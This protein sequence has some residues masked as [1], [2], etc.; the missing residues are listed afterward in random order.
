M[1]YLYFLLII[2]LFTVIGSAQK[3]RKSKE[4]SPELFSLIEAERAFAKM[5]LDKGM[6]NAFVANFADDSVF[7]LKTPVNGK[8][9][10]LDYPESQEFLTWEPVFA[11]ISQAG[12]L[13]YTT[14]F[15]EY[16]E[17]PTD[18]KA[19]YANFISV[20]KKQPDG[21]WK[22]ALDLGVSNPKPAAN[23]ALQL[24]NCTQ[25]GKLK[26][27]VSVEAERNALLKLDRELSEKAVKNGFS[28]TLLS[29]AADNIRLFRANEFPYV[30]KKAVSKALSTK[31]DLISWQPT[32]VEVANSGDL[33]YLY[34]TYEIKSAGAD[35]KVVE[36]G[37]YVRI[38]KKQPDGK[39]KI[40]IDALHPVR[41]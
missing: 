12:D 27:K 24:P 23:P 10:W 15:S 32:R 13:G 31:S 36:K 40:A 5:S 33:G 18:E 8:K 19:L 2:L 25:K 39:W 20:W 37:D 34:G 35:A 17:T 29:N 26:E 4:C 21:A 3:T 1:K 7:F 16:R 38:W 14:G 9:F 11:D 41:G 30:G 28:K 6:K 22:V